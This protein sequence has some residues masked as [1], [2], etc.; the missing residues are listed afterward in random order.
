MKKRNLF[1]KA[2]EQVK[3]RNFVILE[4]FG[5]KPSIMIK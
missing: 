3:K 4:L 5:P 2:I 1:K